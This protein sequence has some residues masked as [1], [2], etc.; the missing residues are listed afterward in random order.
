MRFLPAIIVF[1][2]AGAGYLYTQEGL[3]KSMSPSAWV[4]DEGRAASSDPAVVERLAAAPKEEVIAVPSPEIANFGEVFRFD[5]TPQAV[6]QIWSRVSTGLSDVRYQGYRVP[7]VTGTAQTDLAGSLTFYF[8]GKPKLRRMTFL[9]STADPQR[10]VEFLSKHYG[11]RRVQNSDARV[12]S[13][14][15]RYRYS[16]MLHVTPA[17]VLDRHQAATNYRVELSLE[18]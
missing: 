9:G 7:L 11:F 16:G 17:E 1:G 15:V 2:A 5:W 12:T 14:R 13:Y 6:A 4:S 10:L 8:D 3:V 18:R